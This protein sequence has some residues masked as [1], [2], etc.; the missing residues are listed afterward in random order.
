[1]YPRDLRGYGATPP[2]PRWPN[3]ARLAVQFVLNYEEGGERSI[4]HGDRTSEGF[5]TEEPARELPN[6]RDLNVESQY[7]YGS[8]AG[9]W[10]LHR[11]FVERELPLT[12]FGIT[13]ALERNPE[14]VE[15][16]KAAEW[17]IACHG[18]RW[19]NYSE[20]PEVEEERH[21]AE[22]LARHTAATGER[23][24]GWYTGRMSLNTRRLLVKAGGLV[25]DSDSFADDLPYWVTVDGVQHLV[26]P[27]TL[28]NND[29]RFLNPYGYNAASFSTYLINAFELLR[30][31]G[32]THPKMMSIGLHGR[33]V[34]RPGRAA[35]L[36]RFLDHVAQANDVWVARRVDIARHWRASHPATAPG[37]AETSGGIDS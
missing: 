30:E 21:I 18:L 36:S 12:I 27:Y 4:L 25:Y 15:A 5:L 26:V 32:S 3:G 37:P 31:E 20:M 24:E 1:M 29:I 14:A 23:P 34:G 17:E 10:R 8:R 22:A 16:M 7:E 33:I 28:D 9:F 11:L 13:Q 35:D 2:D 6:L 19:I